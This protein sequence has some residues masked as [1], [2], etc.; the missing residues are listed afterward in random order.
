MNASGTNVA[1]WTDWILHGNSMFFTR[2]ASAI[3][4]AGFFRDYNAEEQARNRWLRAR[5][6]MRLW[7]YRVTVDTRPPCKHCRKRI[8]IHVHQTR[9]FVTIISL[10]GFEWCLAVPRGQALTILS[11]LAVKCHLPVNACRSGPLMREWLRKSDR[12]RVYN[13]QLPMNDHFKSIIAN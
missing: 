5:I 1:W 6:A 13:D 8:Y 4:K 7:H 12:N 9:C 11:V 10:I 2:T 3:G